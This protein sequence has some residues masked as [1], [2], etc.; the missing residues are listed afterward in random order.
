M[1]PVIEFNKSAFKHGVTEADIRYAMCPPLYEE[2]LEL[3]IN[4]WL[5]IGYEPYRSRV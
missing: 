5:I 3:Y 1:F 4:K 2:L